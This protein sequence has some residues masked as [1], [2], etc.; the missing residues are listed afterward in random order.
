MRDG[1]RE[2]KY[3]VDEL[4]LTLSLACPSPCEAYFIGDG[5]TTNNDFDFLDYIRPLG[6]KELN[7]FRRALHKPLTQFEDEVRPHLVDGDRYYPLSD[8]K[9]VPGRNHHPTQK[10]VDGEEELRNN[11]FFANCLEMA[12]PIGKTGKDIYPAPSSRVRLGPL[13]VYSYEF[14][15]PEIEFFRLQLSW[16]RTAKK[17]KTETL[18]GRFFKT[19][20]QW[21]DFAGLTVCWSGGKSLHIHAAFDTAPYLTRFQ[22]PLDSARSGLIN[23]WKILETSLLHDLEL[24]DTRYRPDQSLR[25]PEQYRRLPNGSRCI[26][27]PGHL[28]GIPMG[29]TVPQVTLWEE[30]R[31]RASS[32]ATAMFHSPTHFATATPSRIAKPKGPHKG[33]VTDGDQYGPAEIAH[34]EQRLREIYPDTGWPKLAHIAFEGGRWCARFYNSAS[35][36]NP[37]SIMREDYRTILFM[38]ADAASLDPEPLEASLGEMMEQW[39]AELRPPNDTTVVLKGPAHRPRRKIERAF[40]D[41]NEPHSARTVLDQH[42]PIAILR[43]ERLLIQAPEGVTKT[44][45]IIQH[46]PRIVTSLAQLPD[47]NHF[48]R[49]ALYAFGDYYTAGQK[50]AD[51]NR[52]HADSAFVGVPLLSFSKAYE[53]ACGALDLNGITRQEAA[54]RFGCSRWDAIESQQPS[55][56][57]YFRQHHHDL[58]AKIGDRRPVWFTVHQVAHGWH[59]S[60]PTRTMWAPSFWTADPDERD[61]I[62]RG[63]THLSIVVHDEIKRSTFVE[64]IPDQTRQWI[65]NL[66]KQAG[67]W[68]KLSVSQREAAFRRF[69]GANPLPSAP[70]FDTAMKLA[71]LTFDNDVVTADTGEYHADASDRDLYAPRHG[72]TWWFARQAWWREIGAQRIVFLTT[73]EVPTAVAER[74]AFLTTEEVPTAALTR[75]GGDKLRVMRLDAPKLPSHSIDVHCARG[76]TGDKLGSVISNWREKN[77]EDW[78]AVS[79]K[80]AD[81]P[82][83]LT[84]A[85][86]RGSNELIGKKIVQTMTFMHPDEYEEVQAVNAWTGRGDLVRLRHIDE[87]NQ[88]AG[89]NLGFRH[90]AGAEHALLI[91][92]KLLRQIE[93]ALGY[94]R[95]DFVIHESAGQRRTVRRAKAKAAAANDNEGSASLTLSLQPDQPEPMDSATAG[96][97]AKR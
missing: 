86:A 4:T 43:N 76:V 19:C 51:F 71:N 44:S 60:S 68:T 9:N 39:V 49:Q 62:C 47:D 74:A 52:L 40:S 37:S 64:C 95:Y 8:R 45:T 6:K 10:V 25:F 35:D 11:S 89:R 92:P 55:V 33:E 84:H 96:A 72:K 82:D 30:W 61:R 79:N 3:K 34:C 21:S 77:G 75:R 83:S 17:K 32:K 57:D 28:L 31:A 59:I 42:L 48:P 73:E 94:S 46:H 85:R 67:D 2:N 23:H 26:D 5:M 88:T 58:W 65:E 66:K 38:G 80:I 90:C 81:M 7:Q 91:S 69:S 53:D 78:F 93:P 1:I 56:I 12:D 97:T 50:C 22:E 20:S 24:A 54:H 41:A 87:C 15:V 27:K 63:E 16:L 29:A 14:D 13:V 18:I 70:S 36:H